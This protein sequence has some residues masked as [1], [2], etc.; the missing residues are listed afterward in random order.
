MWRFH[1]KYANSNSKQGTYLI[2]NVWYTDDWGSILLSFLCLSLFLCLEPPWLVERDH[3]YP[4]LENSFSPSLICT[5]NNNPTTYQL[6]CKKLR[7]QTTCKKLPHSV[8]DH[9]FQVPNSKW[10]RLKS[11]STEI[12]SSFCQT[13]LFVKV[14]KNLISYVLFV[15][16]CSG[17]QTYLKL[18]VVT[19]RFT[20]NCMKSQNPST[21]LHSHPSSNYC[22]N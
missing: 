8:Q 10:K 18:P 4:M 9:I 3:E 6:F 16:F 17:F 5:R 12:H 7:N 22:F 20:Q 19:S 15:V 13:V 2:C 11:S 21:K 14:Q 1:L